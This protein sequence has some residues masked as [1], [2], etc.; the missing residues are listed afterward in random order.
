MNVKKIPVEITLGRW[1]R[2][3]CWLAQRLPHRLVWWCGFV[4]LSHGT[5]GKHKFTRPEQL[6]VLVGL[7]RWA[8]DGQ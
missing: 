8:D 2:L 4:I 5:T 1:D 3:W 7:R 6:T